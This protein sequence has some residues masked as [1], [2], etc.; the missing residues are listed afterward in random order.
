MLIFELP[1]LLNRATTA[2]A[3]VA[4]GNGAGFSNVGRCGAQRRKTGDQ[5]DVGVYKCLVCEEWADRPTTA[6]W[7][8]S[9]FAR[10]SATN[11]G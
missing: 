9:D 3:P 11:S 6:R 2:T 8:T 10:L 1:G 7:D 5:D 4:Q